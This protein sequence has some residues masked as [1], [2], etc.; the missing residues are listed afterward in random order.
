LDA[1]KM[2]NIG[3]EIDFM[4][5]HDEWNRRDIKRRREIEILALCSIIFL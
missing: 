3:V 5:K 1:S 4:V 2:L